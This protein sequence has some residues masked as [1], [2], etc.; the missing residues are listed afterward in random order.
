MSDR[1]KKIIF[2]ILFALISV[3]IGLGLWYFFFRPLVAPPTPAVEETPGGELPTAGTGGPGVFEPTE[4]GA[5]TPGVPV[6]IRPGVP[7]AVTPTRVTL[8]QDTVT[9]AVVPDGKGD[10]ARFYNPE[11]GRFYRVNADGTVTALGDKQFLNVKN[12]NWANRDDQ[13]IL[14]FPDGSNVFYNFDTKRQV[15]LPKHWQDFDFSP[16]DG[17]VAALSV[18]LDPSNRFLIVSNP[19]GNEAQAVEALG[20][21]AER[22]LVNW[23]PNNQVIAFSFTGNPQGEG[24]QEVLLIGEN[25]ENFKSL[26]VPGRGF[27]P[28]WSPTGRQ[29]LYSVYHERTEMKPSLWIS[30]GVGDAIGEDRRSINLQT[31][32]DKCAW[33]DETQ[34]VCGVPRTL[35]TGAGLARDRF[36]SVPD[37]I[38]L[39]DLR[40]GVSTKISTPE[41]NHPIRN[42]VLSADKKKLM[43]SDAA[44]GRLYSYDLP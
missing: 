9:Q 37:D 10:G 36:Q 4:P 17:R 38:F 23:S 6:Q 20:D 43:F 21:N 7:T 3:A 22:V 24:A 28:N 32:A 2:A 15:T 8:L 19:D 1:T 26:I 40:T 25:R 27:L 33:K 18:G 29:V 5:L 14:E 31:W 39:V 35:D 13:A 44:N 42:P 16:D 11:D 34:V 41:Q 30:G 12:V